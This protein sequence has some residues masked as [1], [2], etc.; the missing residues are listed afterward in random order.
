MDIE[1]IKEV[2]EFTTI[3]RFVNGDE[4][5]SDG[6]IYAFHENWPYDDLS[7]RGEHIFPVR[8]PDEYEDDGMTDA[9]ADA[10]V[11]RMAGWGT[12]EDYGYYGDDFDY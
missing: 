8:E 11:L 6:L 12:D 10:D 1:Q 2:D 3:V 5:Y 4:L 9:E 7:G